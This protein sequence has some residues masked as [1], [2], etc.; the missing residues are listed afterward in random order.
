MKKR[1]TV[2]CLAFVCV[3][4]AVMTC[5]PAWAGEYAPGETLVVFRAP[6]GAKMTAASLASDGDISVSVAAAAAS[7]GAEVEDTFEAISEADGKIFVRV[8]SA[9]KSTEELIAELKQR[10]D[11]IAASP[12]WVKRSHER[13]SGAQVAAVPPQIGL[14]TAVSSRTPDDPY[15]DQLWGIKKIR[16]PEAWT[17][18]TGSR[19][20]YAAVIGSGVYRHPDL[21]A[22]IAADLGL[23]TTTVS[24]DY[25][26]TFSQWDMDRLGYGTSDAGIIGAVGDNGAGVVGVN[27]SVSMI[28][29]R[30]FDDGNEIETIS[31][32]MRVIDYLISLLQKNPDMKLASI[33]MPLGGF[34][35]VTPE[36]MQ[37]DVY[38]MAYRAL[39]RTNRTL[40]VVTAG[41]NGVAIGEP[42]PFKEPLT[43]EQIRKGM[44]P[45]FYKE[46]YVYPAAFTGLD[47][48]IVVGA[49]DSNDTAPYF[50]NWGERVDIAAP[51]VDILSTWSPL[52]EPSGS[53]YYELP[54]SATPYVAGAAAL[55]L[56]A[57]PDATPAQIKKALLDGANTSINPVVYPYKYRYAYEAE[58]IEEKICSG[59]IDEAS[60]DAYLED[61]RS[62]LAPYK[63]LDGAGRVS[64]TG[65]LD[66]KKSLD[67]LTAE[68]SASKRSS[69]SGCDV[70]LWGGAGLLAL[71]CASLL[72]RR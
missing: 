23:N 49:I 64:R 54:G 44:K 38:W 11:V 5:V 39:D 31:R 62:T 29:I 25:D 45:L 3:L 27:W 50:T 71:A 20:I 65:L 6:E 52:S 22:N 68:M 42:A 4:L 55:L 59:E 24:G 40:I 46:D 57:C 14:S 15:F 36:Q 56:S 1:F 53:M 34:F 63:A 41:T 2:F 67:L 72:R 17:T 43:A 47:N 30:V 66:V 16:A 10:P 26:R 51:G 32:E 48:L 70:S 28:P 33:Y 7:V 35:P 18:T 8:R 12:N 69:S 9:T 21:N 19:E 13:A 60:R 37:Q 58:S 61:I